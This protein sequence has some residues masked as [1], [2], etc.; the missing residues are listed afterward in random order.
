MRSPFRVCKCTR[1]RAL[2]T[3]HLREILNSA[4]FKFILNAAK[5]LS[6]RVELAVLGPWRSNNSRVKEVGDGDRERE[7]KERERDGET[8]AEK[9]GTLQWKKVEWKGKDRGDR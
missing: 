4:R 6:M 8:E 2:Y 1:I 5:P 7:K 3:F 9:R